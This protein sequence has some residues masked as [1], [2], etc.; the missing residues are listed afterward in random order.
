[1][2]IDKRNV[3]IIGSGPAGLSA[4]LYTARANLFPLVITGNALGGQVSLTHQVENYPGFP[5]GISGQELS[6]AFSNQAEKFGAELDYDT[7]VDVDFSQQPYR[8][9]TEEVEYAAD[10]VIIA[11]GASPNTLNVP[12]EKELIGLG[13]S[14]CATCDG[15]FFRDKNVLV[16]GGGDS[17]VEEG[18]FLTKFAKSVTLIHRRDK[19]RAGALLQQ[20]AMDNKKLSFIWDSVVTH[21]Y[22][23]DFVEK[24]EIK[25]LK[26]N[27]SSTLQFDGVFIFIGYSPNTS[28]YQKYINLNEKGYIIVNS[29]MQTNIKGIFAAGEV[30]DELYRQVITSAGMGAAA[31]IQ[32]IRYLD[33]LPKV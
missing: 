24:V 30:C 27:Q 5:D 14:Y 18:L 26:T 9:F 29:S 25:N 22:G 12:G 3:V 6:E 31:A 1:M 13:V 19:L 28:I 32:A 20:R 16:V 10:A 7:V 8:V 17:A 21:I 15:Y 23:K 2:K 4:A 33:N 11:S